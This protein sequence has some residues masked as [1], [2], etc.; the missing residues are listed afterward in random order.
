MLDSGFGNNGLWTS[1]LNFYGAPTLLPSNEFVLCGSVLASPP[2]KHDAIITKVLENGATDTSFGS[3]GV[4]QISF[5]DLIGGNYPYE[6][7]NSSTYLEDGRLV[8]VGAKSSSNTA[9]PNKALMTILYPNGQPDT[10]FGSMGRK[11]FGFDG[12]TISQTQVQ[13]FNNGDVLFMLATR[14]VG[15]IDISSIILF[16]FSPDGSSVTSFG[17]NGDGMAVHLPG[18]AS[19]FNGTLTAAQVKMTK[20]D[21]LLVCGTT[22][23]S[24]FSVIRFNPDGS[25]DESFGVDGQ[26]V[27]EVGFGFQVWDMDLQPDGKILVFGEI[28]HAG[29]PVFAIARLNQDGSLDNTWA[30]NGLM[31]HDIGFYDSSI[32][33]G[34]SQSDGKALALGIRV[35]EDGSSETVVTR[36]LKN[37]T[38]DTS[39]GVDGMQIMDLGAENV[40]FRDLMIAPDHSVYILGGLSSGGQSFGYMAKFIGDDYVGTELPKNAKL[41][42]LLS[43]NIAYAGQSVLLQYDLPQTSAVSARLLDSKGACVQLFFSNETQQP[44]VQSKFLELQNK[45]PGGTYWVELTSTIGQTILP[46]FLK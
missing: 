15:N 31:K 45:L 40:T 28:R 30:N 17:T 20:D 3:T 13:R 37:G 4:A 1:P 24:A 16:R 33:L 42:A 29:D 34:A 22:N 9:I 35:L 38:L 44:G 46:I 11:L 8:L 14:L 43:P 18:P 41:Q 26:A 21:K 39:F 36:Y 10:S 32:R 2:E 23:S 25:R 19:P 5:D 6:G 7:L 12:Q 27:A